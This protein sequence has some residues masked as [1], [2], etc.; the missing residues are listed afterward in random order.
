[1]TFDESKIIPNNEIENHKYN[2]HMT[3]SGQVFNIQKFSIHDGPGIRTIVFLKGC[4]LR[5]Q[6]CSN[7]EGMDSL[8][9]LAINT[10]KCLTTARC[11]RCSDL[12]PNKA[13]SN[14]KSTLEINI[15]RSKCDLCGKCENA[16]PS[17]AIRIFGTVM[18]VEQ[19]MSIVEQDDLFY[20]S[21]GGGLTLSGGEPLFQPLFACALLQR[22][23]SYGF[24]T[25]IETS[26]H[27]AWTNVEAV[28]GC[29]DFI[30]YDIKSIDSKKHKSFT[31]VD[32]RLILSNLEKACHLFP[33]RPIC[34]RTP[35]IPGFNDTREDIK[36]IFSFLKALPRKVEY[37]LLPYHQFGTNKYS[38]IGKENQKPSF[39]KNGQKKFEALKELIQI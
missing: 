3:V 14:D 16:C 8:P 39:K 5:C 10:E 9:T 21:S 35:V 36:K 17:K 6:W 22:A 33:H 24:E 27:G 15:D 1:M 19:V 23:K 2:K 13:I 32:N 30:F 29:C 31:G 38:M 28:F 7:P 12:C 25:A 11:N 20:T 18:N 37:E 4:P 26:G 34:V